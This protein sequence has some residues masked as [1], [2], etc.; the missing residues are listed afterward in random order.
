MAG[1]WV[2]RSGSK[3]SWEAWWERVE[4]VSYKA[5][6]PSIFFTP[7]PAAKALY[8]RPNGASGQ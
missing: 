7:K 1:R 6:G 8:T 4:A 3:G 5:S 2:I